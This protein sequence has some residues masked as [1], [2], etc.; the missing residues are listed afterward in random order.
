MKK[1][2][3][4][5][6]GDILVDVSLKTRNT[7]LKLRLGGIV[8]AAR[9][10]WALS[11]LYDIGY[12]A[13]S[14]LD[15]QIKGYL[16]HHGCQQIIKLGEVTG[17]PYVFLVE[18]AKEVG[19][20]GYEFLLRDDVRI[21]YNQDAL[22]TIRDNSYDDHLIISGNFDLREVAKA[23]QNR[24]HVDVSNNIKNIET[25]R[26]ISRKVDTLFVSTSS[27]IFKNN[28]SEDFNSFSAMF[29]GCAEELIL[30]EN[31]G[32]SRGYNFK[33]GK[34]F[35]TGSQPRKISHSIGVGDAFDSAYI[36]AGFGINE[37]EKKIALASWIA[38]EYA[39]TSFPDDFKRG[40][41]RV[42]NSGIDEL[43][44]LPSTSLP[45]ENRKNLHIYIA[46]PDFDFNN[47]E[48]ID[49]LESVLRYHNFTPHRPIKENGQMEENA[50]KERRQELFTK[51]L[52]L[53]DLCFLVIAVLLYDDPG[54]FIEIGYA[55]AKGLP[56]IVFDP[57][58]VADNCML[59]ELPDLVS[60]DLDEI[61]T[62][63]FNFGF[64]K[65]HNE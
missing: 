12:F 40:V 1:S 39:V 35:K 57:F 37:Q 44:A 21:S 45:W 5:L 25:L 30:K 59:T 18:E 14:Y 15:D 36:S 23:L 61:I 38:A 11:I 13:P 27:E 29:N 31:R 55:K 3:I 2:K 56:V 26:T 6:I 19:D 17:T 58:N 7:E 50:S 51:D 32:G 22:K 46:A 43:I 34:F 10:F 47:T 52:E 53:F 49:K 42:L 8:H 24:V 62:E 54:T 20:Q 16:T 48:E 33:Q 9:T 4:C 65:V 60:N 64:K 28:F 41:G 63:V